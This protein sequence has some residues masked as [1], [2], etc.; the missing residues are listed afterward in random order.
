MS[1]GGWRK[2]CNGDIVNW[3]QTCDELQTDPTGT[4]G[5]LNITYTYSTTINP[6]LIPSNS[7]Y[8]PN[9]TSS[10]NVTAPN[11]TQV[12]PMCGGVSYDPNVHGCCDGLLYNKSTEDCVPVQDVCGGQMYDSSS[13]GCCNDIPYELNTHI[14][15]NQTV[16]E[17]LPNTTASCCSDQLYDTKNST[18]C[19]NNLIP[20][21]V[22]GTCCGKLTYDPV[23]HVCCDTQILA[24]HVNSETETNLCCS[25]G[26]IYD[27]ETHTCQPLTDTDD[28]D[29]E[30]ISSRVTTESSA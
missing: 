8:H 20:N 10:L 25:V 5:E 4:Q 28:D 1:R 23:T 7:T 11:G 3:N 21:I 19:D 26:E 27:A 29:E 18:C 17:K 9:I 16:K 2:C 24:K 6:S 30:T 14:C 12:I 22:D 15:C 13:Q